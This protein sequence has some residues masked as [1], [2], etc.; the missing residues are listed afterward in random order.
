MAF[1]LPALPYEKNALEPYLSAEAL[2][3]H[4]NRHHQACIT[5]LNQLIEGTADADKS[6]EAI[7]T[8][9][10][11]CLFEQAARAWNHTFFWHCLSPKGG[12]KPK[13]ALAEAIDTEYGA[14]ETFKQAFNDMAMDDV[15]AGW[16]WLIKT[17]DGGLA[18]TNSDDADCPV[19]HGRTPLLTVDVR[20]HA[21][22]I[23]Y[24]D[25]RRK[26]LENIWKVMNWEFV[27]QNFA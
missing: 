11:G 20:E 9:A 14:F 27:A 15:G 23:D 1:E 8:S 6:L 21:Y 7:I 2:E 10:S 12:G 22:Y 16:A 3:Y 13:G 19:A 25:A 24:R 5:R 4:Y 17:G 26:Y 18:I